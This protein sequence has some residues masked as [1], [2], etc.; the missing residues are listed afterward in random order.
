MPDRFYAPEM[1]D[2]ETVSIDGQEAQHMLRVLRLEFGSRVQIFDGVGTQA[3]AELTASARNRVELRILERQTDSAQCGP[4]LVLATAVP[5]GD[6]FRWL[7]E[8]ATELGVDRLIPLSTER[9]VVHPGDGKLARMQQTVIAAC[10]QSGRNRLMEID[11][12]VSFPEF[13]D[14]A[15]PQKRVFIAHP[16]AEPIQAIER[17][18]RLDSDVVLAIGP[19]GGFSDSEIETALAAGARPINL[20]S[21]VLRIETAAVALA[22]FF[23]WQLIGSP[24]K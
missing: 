8:K 23:R 4:S 11:P 10:K 2:S 21:H 5:K 15:G 9:S 12:P 20:G 22:A 3:E 1:C 24:A 18:D 13:L 17:L 19:E 6:R 7:V 14:G 16:E